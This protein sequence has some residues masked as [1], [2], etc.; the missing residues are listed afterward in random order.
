MYDHQYF[1]HLSVIFDRLGSASSNLMG[2]LAYGDNERMMAE[3]SHAI[4]VAFDKIQSE[5]E[6][7]E[8]EAAN[9]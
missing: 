2:A 1:G 3:I 5:L 8:L 9:G 4:R 6:Q 7:A